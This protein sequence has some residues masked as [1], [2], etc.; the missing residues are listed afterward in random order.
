MHCNGALKFR[1]P[2]KETTAAKHE[3]RSFSGLRWQTK[4]NFKPR[5]IQ[6]W[7]M[8]ATRTSD[9]INSQTCLGIIF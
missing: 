4:Q 3:K 1:N 2:K 7:I 8:I 6:D 9:C 5:P